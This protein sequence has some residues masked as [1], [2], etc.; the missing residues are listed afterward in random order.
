VKSDWFAENAMLASRVS[1]SER[2]NIPEEQ[3]SLLNRGGS[4]T[5]SMLWEVSSKMLMS[6]SM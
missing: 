1:G 3:R 2:R 5:S 4:L 6:K